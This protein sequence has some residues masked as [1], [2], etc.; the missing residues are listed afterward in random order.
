M[1]KRF[2]A[3]LCLLA[4]LTGTAYAGEFRPLPIDLSGGAKVDY[5]TDRQVRSFSDPTI[6]VEWDRV[7]SR[8][9]QCTYYYGIVTIKD[10]SQLRTV[11]A[12]RFTSNTK[13]RP[14]VMAQRVNAVLA[15]NGDYCAPFSGN[16]RVNSYVLRQGEIYRDSVEEG[17]DIL[18]ID[19]DGDFHVLTSDMDLANIDKTVVDGKKV[20]NAFQFGPALV[21]NGEKV[22]DEYILDYSHSPTFAEPD[23]RAQ[24]MCI[25]QIDQLHYMVLGCSNY[26]ISLNTLRDLALSIAPCKTVYVLDGGASAQMIFLG[27]RVSRLDVPESDVRAVT[28]IIYFASAYFADGE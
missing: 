18:L 19:E 13:A 1:M 24:R 25:A 5:G 9:W 3:A 28:D 21:L 11:A 15:I 6:S 22:P 2:L 12:G 17:L 4:L 26:G 10:P 23:R 27:R 8:E 20:V 7:V 14:M 16:N